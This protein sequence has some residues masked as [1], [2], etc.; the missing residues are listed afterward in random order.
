[1]K[2][3][4]IQTGTVASTTAW[5]PGYSPRWHPIF[6][7][8]SLGLTEAGD[9]IVAHDPNTGGRLDERRVIQ[10]VATELAA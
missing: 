7:R 5:R 8:Q 2:I 1:M 4:A 6:P 9:V 10:P 3:H